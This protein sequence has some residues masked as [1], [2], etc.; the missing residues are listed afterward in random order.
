MN[1]DEAEDLCSRILDLSDEIDFVAIVTSLGGEPLALDS[2][3]PVRSS[4]P[5]EHFSLLTVIVGSIVE[6]F[7]ERY[8]RCNHFLFNFNRGQ[9]IIF[10]REDVFVVVGTKPHTRP[11]LLKNISSKL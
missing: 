8:G 2:R 4:T 10:P 6:K 7:E 9:V 1:K 3:I 11:E 5:K